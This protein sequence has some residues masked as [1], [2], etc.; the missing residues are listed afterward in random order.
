MG[1]S[2][3]LLRMR[4]GHHSALR[5]LDKWAANPG[6]MDIVYADPALG[7]EAL[8][9]FRKTINLELS[10][11]DCLSFAVMKRKGIQEAFTFDSDFTGF[12]F[13]ALP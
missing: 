4:Y 1:E 8:Q 5:F 2:A 3:T 11:V 12:G 9:I 7:A 13:H 6:A 10:Y